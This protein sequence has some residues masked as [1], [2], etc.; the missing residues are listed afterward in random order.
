MAILTPLD[1]DAARIVG[2][3]FGL[4]VVSIEGLLAGSVNSNF[5]LTTTTGRYFLR[6]VEEQGFEGA[7]REARLLALLA[8]RGVPTPEPVRRVDGGGHTS[9]YAEKPVVVFPFVEGRSLAQ[10]E[11]TPAVMRVVGRALAEVHAV[12]ASLSPDELDR[13]AGPSR[14]EVSAMCA[15]LDGLPTNVSADV[16]VARDRLRA[17]FECPTPPVGTM[18]L[19]HGDLFRDNVLF[20]GDELVALLDFESASQ[21][22][23]A[24]DVMVTALAWCFGDD[25]DLD[26]VRALFDGYASVRAL[27]PAN[28]LFAQ[29]RAACARFATTRITD[30]ELRPRGSGVYKDFRRFLKRM[31]AVEALGEAGI[32]RCAPRPSTATS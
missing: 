16:A 32:A 26:L 6:I 18:G 11:I 5:A 29:A 12:G 19:I 1:L 2:R 27:P 4:E 10:R 15:R 23:L 22:S 20:R 28:E 30:F 8:G 13:V 17:F 31:D 24:F 25:L 14:F 3:D 9:R 21:G 7:A